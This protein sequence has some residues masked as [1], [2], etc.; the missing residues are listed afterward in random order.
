MNT[1]HSDE[2][3]MRLSDAMDTPEGLTP[4]LLAEVQGHPEARAFVAFWTGETADVLAGPL[5]P[6]GI[7]LRQEILALPQRHVAM[8]S[9]TAE[10]ADGRFKSWISAAAA[11]AVLF[12]CGWLLL[13]GGGPQSSTRAGNE[14]ASYS[15]TTREVAAIQ[16]DFNSGIM[17]AAQPLSAVRSSLGRLDAAR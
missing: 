7:E 4:E 5:P 14:D 3:L 12:G 16:S 11:A 1:N 17:A 8:A 6:C 2:L 9:S 13:Q 15:L 10:P